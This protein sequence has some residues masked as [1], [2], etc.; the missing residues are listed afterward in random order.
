MTQAYP[1]DFPAGRTLPEEIRKAMERVKRYGVVY[2]PGYCE[3]LVQKYE[4]E[5]IPYPHIL[6]IIGEPRINTHFGYPRILEQEG[7]FLDYGCGTGDNIRQ[8]IRDGYRRDNIRAFDINRAS[9]DLGFDLYRDRADIGDVF[10][11]SE[12]FPYG[13]AGFDTV[14]SASVFHVIPGD[15]ELREYLHNAYSTL[16]TGGVFFGSTLG[17]EDGTR[18]SPARWGPPRVITKTQL[19]KC[20]TGAG[21]SSPML[22]RREHTHHQVNEQERLYYFEFYAEKSR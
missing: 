15:A 13:E 17:V 7:R 16:D 11:V 19:E 18:P 22:V 3:T 12:D 5:P 10:V 4:R 1:M 9:I 6:M 21:F 14:Y 20:L 8:L 2:P